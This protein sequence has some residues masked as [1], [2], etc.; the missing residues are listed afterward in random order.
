M[1]FSVGTG[2][3]VQLGKESAWGS[4]AVGTNIINFTSESMKVT[5][6]KKDEGNLVAS[7]S[8]TARD[9]MS[10]K[11][12]GSLSFILR[13]EFAGFLMKAAFGGTDTV[14]TG[15]PVVGANT[16]SIALV[17]AT[18]TLPSYTVLVDR[19]V[20]V[21]KYTGMK[22]DSLQLDA[23]TGDYVKGTITVKAK[24]EGTGTMASLTPLALQSFRCI[25]ATLTLAG[26]TYDVT[27]STFK[28]N[29]KLEDAPQTY[30]SG[31]YSTEPVHG[32][33]EI[34]IDF[35]MPYAAAID[36]LSTTN[37][38]TETKV[39]TA[40]L[41]LQSPSMVTGTTPYQVKITMNNV[42]ITDVSTN[43][44]GTGLIS[45]KVSGIAL[46]VGATAPAIVEVIDAT[47]TAY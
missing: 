22:V 41:T 37:Y 32:M 36:T 30:A 25:N 44:G 34:T 35:E 26:T 43:V 8:P 40:I 46:S 7:V 10:I 42:A 1:A 29:N 19:K 5:A 11:V 16:H 20:S 39:A 47:A 9:L 45:S 27:G 38:L 18:G 2:A 13:P 6:D 31:L 4:V 33:R 28:I 23:K 17:S 12:D 24:D 14:A 3:G 15:S 21:K